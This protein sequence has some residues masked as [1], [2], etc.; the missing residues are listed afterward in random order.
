MQ[1]LIPVLSNMLS[2]LVNYFFNLVL[3]SNASIVT[4]SLYIFSVKITREGLVVLS[5]GFVVVDLLLIVSPKVAFCV[6]S[7]FCCTLLCVLSSFAIILMGKRELVA[8]LC[9]SSRCPVALPHG[10]VSWSAVCD[11]GIF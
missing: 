9:L 7:M 10:A 8:L 11:C 1:K 5:G 3:L 4:F 6:C 2:M